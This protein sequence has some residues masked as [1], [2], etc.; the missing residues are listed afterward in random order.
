MRPGACGVL[1][2]ERAVVSTCRVVQVGARPAAATRGVP[3]R[4][5]SPACFSGL[6]LRTADARGHEVDSSDMFNIMYSLR[7][8]AGAPQRLVR[9]PACGEHER[10]ADHDA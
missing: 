7:G 6:L 1:D 4:L 5:A 10:G 8:E 9:S 3:V 2:R